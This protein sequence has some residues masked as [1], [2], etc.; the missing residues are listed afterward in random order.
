MVDVAILS[1]VLA[2]LVFAACC[3]PRAHERDAG[4]QDDLLP[5]AEIVIDP[6]LHHLPVATVLSPGQPLQAP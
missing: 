5:T 6:P 2:A 3:F 4:Y 1:Y